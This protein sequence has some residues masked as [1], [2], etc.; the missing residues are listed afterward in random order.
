MSEFKPGDVVAVRGIVGGV[1]PPGGPDGATHWSVE[2]G[3]ADAGIWDI[4]DL[5]PWPDAVRITALEALREAVVAAQ[6]CSKCRTIEHG[7]PRAVASLEDP[8]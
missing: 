2:V 6:V 7:V 8:S 4:E 3:D 5:A 1:T